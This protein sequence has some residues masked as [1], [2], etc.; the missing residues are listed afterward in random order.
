MRYL[1]DWTPSQWKAQDATAGYL[2]WCKVC[3]PSM[4]ALTEEDTRDIVHELEHQLSND[5]W[6]QWLCIFYRV[7]ILP[8]V[9]SLL[10]INLCNYS[11]FSNWHSHIKEHCVRIFQL[12]Y[13][14]YYELKCANQATFQRARLGHAKF[15]GSGAL[16]DAANDSYTILANLVA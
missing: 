14:A 16:Y 11:F 10:R 2:K 13:L 15:P 5:T 8:H 6:F 9:P 3:D 12:Q 7:P 1:K 4:T